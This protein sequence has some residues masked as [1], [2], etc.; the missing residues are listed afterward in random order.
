M[1]WIAVC[2]FCA[3]ILAGCDDAQPTQVLQMPTATFA[4]IVTATDFITA[5]LPPSETPKPIPTLNVSASPSATNTIPP[6]ITPTPATIAVVKPVG[7]AVN[8][9]EGPG[10]SFEIIEALPAGTRLT[11]L[12]EDQEASSNWIFVMIDDG[13]EGWIHRTLLDIE[14]PE[15]VA[16]VENT[17]TVPDVPPT[18]DAQPAPTEPPNSGRV[19]VL[20]YCDLFPG[21][22]PGTVAPGASVYIW[23][24]WWATTEE[25]L[26]QHVENANYEVRIDGTLLNDWR[27]YASDIVPDRENPNRPAIEWHVPIGQLPPGQHKVEYRLTWDQAITDG[28][29]DYGPGTDYPDNTG[30]CTFT[31]GG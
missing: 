17:S 22:G 21:S 15:A 24:S 16:A 1:K 23:W 25:Y 26:Q 10:T 7:E 18:E 14:T 30:T 5:T 19:D 28:V 27:T 11:V 8:M 4:P 2:V 29:D 20:A 9:R 31:V 3:L 6:T 12:P 13:R